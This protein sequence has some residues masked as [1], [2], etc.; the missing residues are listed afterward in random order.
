M[1]LERESLGARISTAESNAKQALDALNQCLPDLAQGQQQLDQAQTQLSN[2]EQANLAF[3]AQW[4]TLQSE[5]N[6]ATRQAE[7]AKARI[8]SLEEQLVFL[9]RRAEQLNQIQNENQS[10]ELTQ[11]QAKNT[12]TKSDISVRVDEI[13]DKIKQKGYDSLTD[14]EKEVLYQ[15][16]KN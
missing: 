16:S 14:E 3:Q 12:S 1:T 10:E 2:V 13:L 9:T 5:Q 4:D 7:S 11:K 8:R 15:A 6:T